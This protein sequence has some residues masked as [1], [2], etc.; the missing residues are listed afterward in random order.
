MHRAFREVS[1]KE[2][3]KL[4]RESFEEH[5]IVK[6]LLAELA[7]MKPKDE[8][9]DAKVTVLKEAVEHHAEE[10]EDELFPAAKKLFPD[11]RLRELGAEMLDIKDDLQERLGVA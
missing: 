2:P 11:R 5:K 7:G 1:E 10:E 9:F 4:V 3:K 8:Q 6:T